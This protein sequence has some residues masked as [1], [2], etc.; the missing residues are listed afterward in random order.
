VNGAKYPLRPASSPKEKIHVY[1]DY[2]DKLMELCGRK[3]VRFEVVDR[4]LYQF[5]KAG[6]EPL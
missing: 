6:K 1:F 5:D 4:I 2:I 3:K